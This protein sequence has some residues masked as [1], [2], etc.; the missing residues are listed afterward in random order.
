MRPLPPHK[1]GPARAHLVAI[2]QARD[3]QVA[4]LL[5]ALAQGARIAGERAGIAEEAEGLGRDVQPA[6]TGGRCQEGCGARH[7]PH[8]TSPS[9]P[10]RLRAMIPLRSE[11]HTSELQS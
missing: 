6:P 2:E 7:A 8:A 9:S 5:E 4:V 11:E 1:V 10:R 3:E